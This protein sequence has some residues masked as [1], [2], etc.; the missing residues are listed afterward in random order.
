MCKARTFTIRA[1]YTEAAAVVYIILRPGRNLGMEN[2]PLSFPYI[3]S[4]LFFFLLLLL[5]LLLLSYRRTA[6]T[7]FLSSFFFFV[8]PFVSFFFFN[9]TREYKEEFPFY[10][11]AI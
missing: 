3:L 9:P 11:T 6:T 8:F 4:I 5:L 2:G 1:E 7:R 10:R